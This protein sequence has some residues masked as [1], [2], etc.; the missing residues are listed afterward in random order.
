MKVDPQPKQ[1]TCFIFLTPD[2]GFFLY[3]EFLEFIGFRKDAHLLLML[4]CQEPYT[5]C[6]AELRSPSE[7]SDPRG[8]FRGAGDSAALM[9]MSLQGRRGHST[10]QA[11][12]RYI[13]VL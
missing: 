5:T 9:Q 6:H 13:L 2:N 8:G 3:H 4:L 1:P 12:D 11:L 10:C 7:F